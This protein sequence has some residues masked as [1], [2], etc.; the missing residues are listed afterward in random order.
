MSS[1]YLGYYNVY[2]NR[3]KGGDNIKLI[4]VFMYSC[5]YLWAMHIY[6]YM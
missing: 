3:A 6:N 5:A 4:N 1:L 2:V